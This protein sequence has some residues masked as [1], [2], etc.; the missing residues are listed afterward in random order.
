[1]RKFAYLVV[2]M[3]VGL[4]L[5]HAAA[6][7]S[8]TLQQYLEFYGPG[9]LTC[10]MAG[11][12]LVFGDFT[13]GPT[14]LLSNSSNPWST[15][16]STQPPTPPFA[17]YSQVIATPFVANV[18]GFTA[19][20]FQY[21]SINGTVIGDPGNHSDLNVDFDTTGAAPSP[22]VI[23]GVFTE[24]TGKVCDSNTGPC[25]ITPG[26]WADDKFVERFQDVTTPTINVNILSIDPTTSSDPTVN[27]NCPGG[28]TALCSVQAVNL[29]SLTNDTIH[30]DTDV[31]ARGIGGDC[32]GANCGSDFAFLT[33]A[34]QGVFTGIPVM[35]PEP[36]TF[37][38]AGGFLALVLAKARRRRSA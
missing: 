4:R 36:S 21:T 12:Q 24:M 20:G 11:M 6:C 23:D 1:M 15:Q 8:M 30:T 26:N 7:T 28:P 17:E 19:Y 5:G 25:T 31:D 9:G 18:D 14:G 3:G 37:A 29:F 32:P 38:L 22:G 34:K 16:N 33:E 13:P 27:P 2:L 10:T 35:T